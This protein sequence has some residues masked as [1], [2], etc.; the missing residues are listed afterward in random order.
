MNFAHLNLPSRPPQERLETINALLKERRLRPLLGLGDNA[1]GYPEIFDLHS[2]DM[3]PDHP[4]HDGVFRVRRANGSEYLHKI[5]FNQN[6]AF[7]DGVTFI[8]V[9]NERIALTRQFRI[10]V[11]MET[12]EL[13]R[14]LAET[15]DDPGAPQPS[16]L[17]PTLVR[18]LGE[19]VIKDA[20]ISSVTP[21]G[22]LA[23]N[24]G[25]SNVWTEAYVVTIQ[26]DPAALSQRLGGTQELGVRLV[27][28]D[29]LYRPSQL[30]IRDLHSLAV[31]MLAYETTLPGNNMKGQGT[32]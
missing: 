18:E 1:Q 32:S 27:T 4:Y 22:S 12:W 30:G 7:C 2:L 26:A 10:C 9:I 6:G 17:P 15:A 31:I 25:T 21:L 29:E 19:E 16:S 11:G 23:E 28:W 24:T 14:G 8:P 20:T 3:S 13:A 5:R